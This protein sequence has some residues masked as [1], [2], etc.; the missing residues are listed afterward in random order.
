VTSRRL[1]IQLYLVMLAT[2]LLCLVGVGV[3]FRYVR[4]RPG[5]PTQRLGH[6]AATLAETRPDL[7]GEDGRAR[8]AAVADTLS[9]DVII[10]D[11]R[12]VLM[13]S[14]AQRP[15]P[16]PARTTPGW[17]RGGPAGPVLVV[18]LDPDHWAAVRP[19]PAHRGFPGEPFFMWLLALA[20][21]MALASYP[22]ARWIT[23]RLE[24]L[25]AGVE[26]WG[27][28]ELGLRVPV[29]GSDEVATLAATFNQAAARIDLLVEQQRQL[30]A[31]T[32]HE[33]RS[34][35]ARVRMG[36]ELAMEE[37]DP[38]RRQ[39]RV[40][41]IRRDIVE[42][43]A[44]I[45]ELLLF[46]RADTRV[47]RRP[48]ER[49]ELRALFASEAARTGATV[50][51]PEAEVQG[52]AV[53]L[54]HVAR[55]LFENAARHAG[56]QEVRA[57]IEPAAPPPSREA[58]VEPRTIVVAV[59]DS[60]PGIP[61]EDREKIFAPFYRRPDRSAAPGHGLGLALVR[62]VARY[63]GGDARHVPRPGGGS[64]FEVS[65]PVSPAPVA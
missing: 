43:D 29:E 58:A 17:R 62:Q 49:V 40:E 26:R 1:H 50:V 33:L 10:G 60:G 41:D 47:P 34:P 53:L 27:H 13:S 44:L 31:N 39:Q 35:L 42:L 2:T 64:R 30:L 12:G 36:L 18:E 54:R 24:Q 37:V 14:P 48:F 20:V 63:H 4:E 16:P 7:D 38:E 46:A 61:E 55:N 6:A 45:E 22:V 15:F 28:G 56:G 51:G 9:V 11:A 52:D 23:R 65:L 5:S 19:R 8:L 3:A 57:S 59:E 32:S 25:A 21:V